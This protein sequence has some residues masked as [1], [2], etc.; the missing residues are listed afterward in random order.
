MYCVFQ[1]L[2]YTGCFTKKTKTLSGR[3]LLKKIN[4]KTPKSPVNLPFVCSF[5]KI[6]IIIYLLNVFFVVNVTVYKC[7]KNRLFGIFSKWMLYIFNFEYFDTR[8]NFTKYLRD[9]IISSLKNGFLNFV[10]RSVDNR[11]IN[12]N[13]KFYFLV[14]VKLFFIL[15]KRFLCV[16]FDILK[17]M[18]HYTMIHLFIKSNMKRFWNKIIRIRKCFVCMLILAF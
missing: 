6:I 1:K 2:S 3:I 14:R 17:F 7:T 4:P 8:F 16:Q 13:S 5:R 15:R 11:V 12:K 9:K 10:C 18:I